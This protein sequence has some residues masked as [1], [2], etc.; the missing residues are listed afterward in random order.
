MTQLGAIWAQSLDGIIGNG[1]D[2]PWHVPEDLAHFRAITTGYP[3]IMGRR[4]WLSLPE[5]FRP[6]PGRENFVL[7]TRKAG[8]WS[9]GATVLDQ[10]PAEED[11][12]SI[13][14]AWIMGGGQVYSSTIDQVDLLEVTLIGAHLGDSLGDRAV[15]APE[16][17]RDFGL[18]A[19]SDW[20][21]SVRG[22]LD[23]GEHRQ[24]LP[25]RYRFLSYQRKE[26]A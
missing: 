25:L 10:L 21:F 19:D 9:Q 11:L 17:P 26:A 16:I 3:V 12:E 24:D 4:T 1:T 22:R 8:Q 13:D 23:L 14:Q 6:L 2:M 20:L 18:V 5:R 7:S 15:L